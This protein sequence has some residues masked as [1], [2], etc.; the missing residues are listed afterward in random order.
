MEA[1]LAEPGPGPR[2]QHVTAFSQTE[3]CP[4]RDVSDWHRRPWDRLGRC[5]GH[6]QKQLRPPCKGSAGALTHPSPQIFPQWKTRQ[7]SAEHGSLFASLTHSHVKLLIC[8]LITHITVYRCW[9]CSNDVAGNPAGRGVSSGRSTTNESQLYGPRSV[10]CVSQPIAS[11]DTCSTVAGAGDGLCRDRLWGDVGGG[12]RRQRPRQT[13]GGT[14]T[15]GLSAEFIT[16]WLCRCHTAAVISGLCV[17]YL[18]SAEFVTYWVCRCHTA[19]VISGLCV[20]CLMPAEFVTYWVCRCH[21]AAVISGLCVMYLMSAAILSWVTGF[22]LW[23]A[24]H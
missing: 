24:A 1:P 8:L 2:N 13:T 22:K 9:Q 14:G 11:C 3:V 16:Y 19:A 15:K 23:Q 5:R 4:P 6:S 17:L 7:M 21:T 20:M 12:T 18:M 10:G